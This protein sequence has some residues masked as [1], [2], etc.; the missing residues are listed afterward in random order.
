MSRC[1]WALEDEEVTEHMHCS[2]EGDGR[3]WL[4]T[5][6]ATLR[7]EQQVRVFVTDES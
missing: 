5:M 3:A 7:H 4:A 6:I 1:V 2:V